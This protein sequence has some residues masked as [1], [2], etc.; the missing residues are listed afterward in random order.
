MH[1]VLVRFGNIPDG[2]GHRV[3]GR[4]AGRRNRQA[5]TITTRNGYGNPRLGH[6]FLHTAIDDHSRL[7][8]TEILTDETKDTAG[9]FLRRATAWFATAGVRIERVLTDNGSC[10]LSRL[11]ADTCAPLG[12]T[13]NETL[14]ASSQAMIHLA[15][16][17]NPTKRIT[18]ET[19]STRQGI[20]EDIRRKLLRSN[21][22]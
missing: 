11:W 15:S 12:I 5:M 22:L 1:R 18:D 4:P 21:A 2:G 14:P 13:P 19:T 3:L 20:Y 10:Y 8:Y 7:A 6:A 17:D 16:I 9:A